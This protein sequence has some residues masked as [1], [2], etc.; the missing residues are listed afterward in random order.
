MQFR[1]APRISPQKDAMHHV[2][3][4]TDKTG[5]LEVKFINAVKGEDVFFELVLCYPGSHCIQWPLL[6]CSHRS[7]G[8]WLAL[9]KDGCSPATAQAISF[10]SSL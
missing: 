8:R 2:I 5:K 9:A 1:M 6:R 3:T 4:K 10:L 7:Y